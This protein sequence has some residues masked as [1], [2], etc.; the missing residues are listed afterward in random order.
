[1]IFHRIEIQLRVIKE[2][3]Y[4]ELNKIPK[5]GTWRFDEHY[6]HGSQSGLG[7]GTVSPSHFWLMG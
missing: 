2:F 1:M 6:H 7:W 4:A 3:I 5:A